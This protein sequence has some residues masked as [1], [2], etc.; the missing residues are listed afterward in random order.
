MARLYVFQAGRTI[1]ADS[2]RISSSA[3]VPLSE[4]G[5]EEV[6]AGARR[7]ADVPLTAIYVAEGEPEK[8]TARLLAKACGA[9][10][11]TAKALRELD[12]GLWQGLRTEEIK[13]RQPKLYRQWT[14]SPLS[15]R[16]PGGESLEEARQRLAKAM[17]RIVRKHAETAA[18][19]VLRPVVM[20]LLRC[21]V[22]KLPT[23]QIWR[24]TREGFC[25]ET[26]DIDE[27]C[28]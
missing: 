27:T 13:H 22:R 3:G 6:A 9:K 14:E 5:V 19:V 20:G 15:V 25:C 24:Q 12:Y 10:V 28:A 26:C 1:W 11:K 8:Q 16:P 21:M 7:I 17:R 23:E 18:G 2:Q 4:A